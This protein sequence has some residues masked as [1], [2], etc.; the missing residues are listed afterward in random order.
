VPLL[1][2]G[3][4]FGALMTGRIAP[5][6]A[7]VAAVVLVGVPL[8]MGEPIPDCGERPLLVVQGAIDRFGDAAAIPVAVAASGSRN[9]RVHI[10]PGAEHLFPRQSQAVADAVVTRLAWLLGSGVEPLP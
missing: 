7:R 3:Y 1:A 9:A 4:S 10:V 2:A 8:T 5:A 6:D